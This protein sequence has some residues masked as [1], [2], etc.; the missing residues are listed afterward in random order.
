MQKIRASNLLDIV[1]IN[2]CTP[3][4][5]AIS[6][7][8]YHWHVLVPQPVDPLVHRLNLLKCLTIV[9]GIH[10]QETVTFSDIL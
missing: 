5:V 1:L 6:D 10:Q 4:Y 8:S 7:V 2:N 9:N 3:F